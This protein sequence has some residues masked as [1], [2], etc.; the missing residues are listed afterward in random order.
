MINS[1][2]VITSRFRRVYSYL[3]AFVL[4]EWLILYIIFMSARNENYSK[5]WNTLYDNYDTSNIIK[6]CLSVALNL[7]SST[8]TDNKCDPYTYCKN[9]YICKDDSKFFHTYN[10]TCVASSSAMNCSSS[11]CLFAI[12]YYTPARIEFSSA[13]HPT[14][15][16]FFELD[17]LSESYSS[18]HSMGIMT[19]SCVLIA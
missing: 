19:S 18:L 3:S 4:I 11:F 8:I 14:T 17:D 2:S 16:S 7:S 1:S 5:L 10:Y 12:R 6:P 15:T 13:E 9:E